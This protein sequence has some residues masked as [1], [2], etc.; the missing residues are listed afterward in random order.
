MSI[1]RRTAYD[2]TSA[3]GREPAL[4]SWPTGGVRRCRVRLPD[5]V[6]G[7]GVVPGHELVDLAL[8]MTCTFF[9]GALI[10]VAFNDFDGDGLALSDEFSDCLA[11]YLPLDGISDEAS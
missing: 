9:D 1:C 2:P 11:A 10:L 8:R 7:L 4:I 5:H 6:G 3:K